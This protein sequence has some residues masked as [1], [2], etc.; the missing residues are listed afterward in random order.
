MQLVRHAEI[1]SAGRTSTDRPVEPATPIDQQELAH[2]L[3]AKARTE[4]VNLIGPG[5]L[6]TG[7]T[8]DVLETAR[9]RRR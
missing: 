9:S 8:K 2:Q 1:G 5:G 4:G 7:L 6:L 3:T